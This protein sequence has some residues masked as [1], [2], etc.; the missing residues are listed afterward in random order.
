MM[1]EKDIVPLID[2]DETF[3]Q[4]VTLPRGPSAPYCTPVDIV[5]RGRSLYY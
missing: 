4:N 5:G 2:I 1:D 3:Q